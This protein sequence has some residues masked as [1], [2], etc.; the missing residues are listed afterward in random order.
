MEAKAEAKEDKKW[1]KSNKLKTKV[2][3]QCHMFG[4]IK[5]LNDRMLKC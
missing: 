2:A 1:K 5:F 4:I 3:I